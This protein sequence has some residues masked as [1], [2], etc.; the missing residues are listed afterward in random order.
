MTLAAKPL[1]INAGAAVDG[2]NPSRA[3][4]T[5]QGRPGPARG[6]GRFSPDPCDDWETGRK[7]RASGGCRGT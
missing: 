3:A 1:K 5:A 6:A 2:G 7:N 4:R